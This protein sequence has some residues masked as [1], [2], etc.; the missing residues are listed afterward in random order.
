MSYG[1]IENPLI[2]SIFM[3][4]SESHVVNIVSSSGLQKVPLD[5]HYES[6]ISLTVSTFAL[7]TADGNI[8][9]TNANNGQ[10]VK[11]TMPKGDSQVLHTF[12]I[13]AD[14]GSAPAQMVYR[15]GYIYGG[16]ADADQKNNIGSI[17]KIKPDGTG[18]TVLHKFVNNGD[19]YL[20]VGP[21]V[22]DDQGNIYGSTYGS[23]YKIDNND[24]ITFL[25]T[26]FLINGL[27]YRGGYLYGDTTDVYG[28]GMLFKITPD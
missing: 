13:A 11:Y 1:L 16:V 18:Y 24:N 14:G 9:G 25:K 19:G 8:Y 7:Q 6:D 20:P 3:S 12:S 5:Q 26:P 21:L 15:N 2:G 4:G 28:L 10:L 23:L 27:A 22:T 17:W